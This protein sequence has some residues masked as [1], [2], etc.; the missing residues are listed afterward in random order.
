MKILT[1]SSGSLVSGYLI[2][3]IKSSGNISVASDVDN[4]NHASHI[5]DEFVQFPFSS[6]KDLWTKI[7]KILLSSKIEIVIPSFDET[8]IDWSLRKNYFLKK[9]IEIIISDPITLDTFLD[10]FNAYNFCLKNQIPTPKTS[11]SQKYS[12]VK[13]R[14]GRGGSGIYV[15]KEKQNMEGMISQ[16]V[17]EGKE[18]TV[19]CFFD[20][21]CNPVYIIP[22]LRIDVV[23]G[24]STKGLVLEHEKINQYVMKISNNISFQ[25]PINFQFMEDKNNNLFFLE[26]NPRIAGGMAL[27]FAASE[28]W[29]SLIV[30]NFIKKQNIKPKP[31]KFGLKMSRYYEE[32]FF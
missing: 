2:N 7:E 16:E 1:E 12:L 26:V 18:Y 17:I 28:N 8:L 29:I 31:I 25:G 11:L 19:D 27:G 14:L 10:K 13:P 21:D 4:F 24:K 15:G 30:E 32:S 22:R 6:E 20:R 9:G 23:N 5:A 3:A